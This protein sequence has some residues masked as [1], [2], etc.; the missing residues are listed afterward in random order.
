[1]ASSGK[2]NRKIK[3][4]TLALKDFLTNGQSTPHGI[5]QVAKKVRG[6]DCEDSDDGSQSLPQLYDLPTAPRASREFDDSSIS[7]SPPFLAYATNLPFDI[8]D[9]DIHN[10][11]SGLHILSIRLPRDD[12]DSG[13][14]KGFGYIEFE[15]RDE[16]IKAISMPEQQIKGRRIKMNIA[17]DADQGMRRKSRR[18]EG[19]GGSDEYRDNTNWRS[20][21]DQQH[22][23]IGQNRSYRYN[24]D[25]LS[26]DDNQSNTSWRT[27]GNQSSQRS[28][29][30]YSRNSDRNW[31]HGRSSAD[32]DLGERPKLNLQPRTLPLPKLASNE[33]SSVHK[34]S[35][36]QG[37]RSKLN[38]K[39]RSNSIQNEE[40]GE[41]PKLNLKPRTLPMPKISGDTNSAKEE[42]VFERPKLNL[43]PRT[44]P[45]PKTVADSKGDVTAGKSAE[46]EET[47]AQELKMEDSSN[48][49][50]IKETKKGN[51]EED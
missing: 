12:G 8:Q 5:T 45:L 28:D 6:S 17:N 1:M 33:S 9:D 3:G 25:R 51:E 2:K 34:Q 44:L 32:D 49:N 50:I 30:G 19:F 29:S 10:V 39:P 46:M 22:D 15:T 36:E 4:T 14:V 13:R 43:Q 18:Y 40:L 23:D 26:N 24:R 7:H 48:S 35:E 38:L 11:F 37:E 47:T 20:N 41:R 31:S 27:G 42:E 21:N 16:L